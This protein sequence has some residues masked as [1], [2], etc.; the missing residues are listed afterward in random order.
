LVITPSLCNL[1]TVSLEL[2]FIYNPG[3][4][5]GESLRFPS[6]WGS[7][8]T[9]SGGLDLFQVPTMANAIYTLPLYGPISAYVGAGLGGVYTELW[10]GFLGGSKDSFSF[11]YQGI[12]G[13]KYALNDGLDI[14]LS[15]K[16]LGS[17][18]H[19]METVKVEGTMS[20]SILA[21]FNFKF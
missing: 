2:G 13:V 11:G 15:Y 19:D 5:G 18:E 9:A 4:S 16:L 20:H 3:R 1:A 17:I 21:A 8:Q 7:W 10:N 12:L 14:G 6:W